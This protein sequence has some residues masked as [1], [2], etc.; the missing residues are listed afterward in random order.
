MNPK[1]TS[2]SGTWGTSTFAKGY[3]GSNYHYHD[4]VVGGT[5]TFT[6]TLNIANSGTYEV[7]ARWTQET[8]EPSRAYDATYTIYHD[9]GNTLVVVDQSESWAGKTGQ[10]HK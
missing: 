1:Y 5:D 6:W 9:G 10:R 4:P 3:Y 8:E 2:Y 7:F